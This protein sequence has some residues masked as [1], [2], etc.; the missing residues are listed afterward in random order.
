M[1]YFNVCCW[2]SDILG[3]AISPDCLPS[4]QHTGQVAHVKLLSLHGY[5]TRVP[6]LQCVDLKMRDSWQ[7]ILARLTDSIVSITDNAKEHQ[8]ARVA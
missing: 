1:K 3:K 6:S 7:T 8:P 2:L 5:V 4:S